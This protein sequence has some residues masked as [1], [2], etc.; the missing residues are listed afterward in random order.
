MQARSAEVRRLVAALQLGG[1]EGPSSGE[2]GAPAVRLSPADASAALLSLS[3]L[4]RDVLFEAEMEALVQVRHHVPALSAP[5]WRCPCWPRK[6]EHSP[7]H[8]LA[9]CRTTS[10]QGPDAVPELCKPERTTF[11]RL[12]LASVQ[13]HQATAAPRH[14]YMCMHAQT[15]PHKTDVHLRRCR[16]WTSRTRARLLSCLSKSCGRSRAPSMQRPA[17]RR[18]QTRLQPLLRAV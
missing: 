8:T 13:L 11:G 1:V 5:Q 14:S 15:Q 2:A 10:G 6:Q 16:A 18:S 7:T 9:L 12:L 17:C 4:G 3:A